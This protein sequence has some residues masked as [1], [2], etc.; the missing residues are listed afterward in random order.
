VAAT[1]KEKCERRR[2][3]NPGYRSFPE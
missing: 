2:T 3:G 1:V